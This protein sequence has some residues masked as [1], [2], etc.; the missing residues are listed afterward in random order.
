M[1]VYN[2]ILNL[3]LD[4]YGIGVPLKNSRDQKTYSY[5]SQK[6]PDQIMTTQTCDFPEISRQDLEAVHDHDF[7]AD[8]YSSQRALAKQIILAYELSQYGEK[9]LVDQE[10]FH[11]QELFDTILWHCRGVLLTMRKAYESCEK[12]CYFLG[13]GMHHAMSFGGRGFCLVNDGVIALEKLRKL[14]DLKN[15]WV[16]DVD[17]HKGDGTAQL[18]QNREW[19][20]TLSL[21]MADFWPFGQPCEN[22]KSPWLIPSDID[23]AFGVGEEHLYLEL[24]E[25]SLRDMELRFPCPDFVWILAGADV[26]E[27]DELPS[28]KGINLTKEQV[29]QRDLTIYNFFK[30]RKTPQGWCLAGGYGDRTWEIPSQFLA[31]IFNLQ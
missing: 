10:S 23:V 25:K 2:K 22:S 11:Y 24:L 28:A 20:H 17:A 16:I 31:Q 3:N 21:H 8:L 13:G 26:F 1:L 18:A 19:L 6:F 27:H 4:R 12:F 5:L 29:L 14:Y 9:D 30:Q 15:I 7:V